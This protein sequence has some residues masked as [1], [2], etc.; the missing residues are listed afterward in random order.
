MG[1]GAGDEEAM[2]RSAMAF[3]GTALFLFA[4]PAHAENDRSCD[5]LAGLDLSKAADKPAHVLSAKEEQFLGR[6]VCQVSGVVEPQVHPARTG[7][8]RPTSRPKN[9]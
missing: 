4:T 8:T 7:S 5:S 3:V 9:S 6:T 1:K 2:V